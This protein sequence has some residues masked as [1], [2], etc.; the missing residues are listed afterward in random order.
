MN[1]S[2]GRRTTERRELPTLS[3]EQF[4]Q[5]LSVPKNRDIHA[6]L[7]AEMPF[8]DTVEVLPAPEPAP[9]LDGPV[10]VLSWNAERCKHVKPSAD[11]L[12]QN[13]TD[14]YLLSEMDWGMAR[15][16]QVHTA[17][18][19]AEQ[20]GC[21][22]VFGVEFL[23]L[24]LG[25]EDERKKHAGETNRVGYH[26]GAILCR[27][28]IVGSRL[29]RLETSGDWFDGQ[30]G[31]RRIGGRIALMVSVPVAGVDVTFVSTH[32]ESES[33][34]QTRGDQMRAIFEAVESFSPEAPAV[35]GGDLNTFSLGHE[36]LKDRDLR[37]QA[38]KED[39][40]RLVSPVQYEPMFTIAKDYGY[41]WRSCNQINEPTTRRSMQS[42]TER[43]KS[44][45]DWFFCRHL[46]TENPR[47]I[48]AVKE[49]DNSALSDHEA[50]AVTVR[51]R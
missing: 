20:L 13:R 22:Y 21:G 42:S 37:A 8:V 30:L 33:D 45:I 47:V 51:V 1:G 15:S 43:G 49:E 25:D 24:D 6:K 11:F 48:S 5:I 4:N 10:Q 44:K 39:P 36:Q 19:L 35:I 23:E 27:Q 17:R 16:G 46:I 32:L 31:E 38:L 18:E 14:I 50:I 3:A 26:G 34:P 29:V 28:T 9:L 2:D 12:E 40:K 7:L 41:Q